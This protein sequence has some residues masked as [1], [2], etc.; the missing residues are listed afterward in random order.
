MNKNLRKRIMALIVGVACSVS[1]FGMTACQP[2]D[3]P[4]EEN[5]PV[6]QT[7]TYTVTFDANGGTLNGKSTVTVE[8]GKKISGAPTASMDGYVFDGWYTAAQGGSK[9][10]L[11]TYEVEANVTLY[12]HY[13]EDEE[14]ENPPAEDTVTVTFDAN[15]GTLT[16]SSSVKIDKN[17]YVNTADIPAVEREGYIFKGWYT[18]KEGGSEVVPDFDS[19]SQNTTLYAR[20]AKSYTVTFDAGEGKLTGNATVEVE[21]GDTIS[22][23]PTAALEGLEFHGWYTEAE[24]GTAVD[25]STYEVTA[26]VTLYA[27]YGQITMPLKNLKDHEGNPVG[28]R[29]E[30]EDSKAEG[31]LS[32][33]RTDGG[34]G[35]IETN[36]ATASGQASIGYF[37]VQGNTL[38]FTFL[39]DKE[40][41]A[42]I[43]LRAASN[44]TQMD[45]S[46]GFNI[47]VDDQTVTEADVTFT[48][49][50]QAAHFDPQVLRGAGKDM[51]MT[52]N[53][54]WDPISLGELEVKE[55]L[56][57]LVVTA[58]AT[59][60]PNIDC[61]DI[62]TNLV[63]TSA[64]G[65]AASGEAQQPAP[66]APEVAYEGDLGVELV[67][68]AYEGGPAVSKAI[69]DFGSTK[70]AKDAIA[71]KPITVMWGGALGGN[72]DKMYLSDAEGNEIQG[73]ESQYVTIEYAV[74][75]SGWSFTGNLSPFVYQT[76]NNWKDISTVSVDI[77][78]VLAIDGVEYTSVSAD[79]EITAE[80]SVPDLETWDLTGK[81]TKDGITLTYGSYGT[82]AMKNDGQKNP[83]IIWLHGAG[84]GGTDPSINI[85][86][87]QVTN[88]SKDLIQKYFTTETVKG[89]YVL[90]PQTPTAWMDKDGS[91][92]YGTEA[93]SQYYVAALKAL[94]DDYIAKNGD[95]DMNRIYIGGC[96]NGGFMTVNMILNF[97]EFFAAAFPVCEAYDGNWLTDELVE[98]IKDMPI[99]FTHSANDNTVSI[100][101]KEGDGWF[102]PITPT[103]PQNAYTNNLYVRLIN[104]GAANVHY[105]LFE[106]VLVDGVN[107]D[108][109]W[110]WIYTLRD[111]CI[112]VQPTQ[113]KDGGELT[114]SDLDPASQEKV[115]ID[116]EAVS[117][118]AWLAA[119]SKA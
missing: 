1:V 13:T 58:Q 111:E 31:T 33:E 27:H 94:I 100:Y 14:E 7:Q 18:E 73:A 97:P 96:S 89:A 46:S 39:S 53:Y 32:S 116:G 64:N 35:F 55:G 72:N 44:N 80:K 41:T 66:P 51:P 75:Y 11:S 93:A 79:A 43:A 8:E 76:V 101:E 42:E 62:E 98:S 50:G 22:G 107:Y 20:W 74:L 104:A 90:A 91:G 108:G 47:W 19:F 78:G 115:E 25:L 17:S 59:T 49:N 82:D 69:I 86:G 40:G 84:E 117:L 112:N 37:G 119:Q 88:L 102:T 92:E 61:L 114:I 87:N 56:N 9:V 24:G 113:G 118:W 109:H 16:G 5:P 2:G 30:A 28:Y 103:N 21:E 23:A 38:T 10:D 36:Q 83:L 81:Y 6:S 106:S 63:L 60:V 110:S 3:G 4:G 29:I 54:Y 45:F 12:A 99:W 52:W 67:I 68:G 15:G 65:D 77:N 85:L 57:T 48:F 26:D 34:E 105:S 95:I 71:S 70:I